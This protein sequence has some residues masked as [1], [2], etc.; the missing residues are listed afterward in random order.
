MNKIKIPKELNIADIEKFYV[1]LEESGS[2]VDFVINKNI[3]YRGF[4]VFPSL[5]LV[6]F[7]W[8]RKK[9]GDFIVLIDQ[10][11]NDSIKEFSS[12]FLG[13][14]LLLS[15]WKH[16]RIVGNN[17]VELK[18]SFRDYTQIL[19]KK[20]DF[21]QDLP[22]DNVLIPLYDHYSKDKGLSHWFYDSDFKFIDSPEGLYTTVYRIFEELGK[23]FKTKIEK[24]V[25]DILDD[26]QVIIWEL[27]KNTHDHATKDEL[28]EVDLSP[29][30][31]G[32]YLKIHR[33][34]KEVFIENAKES[35][36]LQSYYENTLKSGDNFILE[37]SVFD[38]GP[39]LAKRF[40]GREWKENLLIKEEVNIIKRCLV[41]GV[42]SL[43][44]MEG[45]IRGY[46][47]N[48]VLKTLSKKQGFLKIRSG[49]AALYR[50]L[51][52]SPHFETKEY[53]E[54][55][56]SD[57]MNDTSNDYTQMGESVGTLITMSYPLI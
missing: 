39:G 15:A 21:L 49:K 10:N 13:Y 26:L 44:G 2:E 16:K 22:N 37:I 29:N 23:V 34:S 42:S 50:D 5:L 28:N 55:E 1:D 38:S 3:N 40:L 56:L 27:I 33:S 46:G 53:S 4:G 35:T 17:N 24:N 11:D 45:K 47:L 41:K 32:L 20:I 14:S 25:S 7:T 19:H 48:N 43:E 54:I 9:S 51:A 18:K 57:W 8:I 52:R 30:I 31:R 6:F 36:G 12:N